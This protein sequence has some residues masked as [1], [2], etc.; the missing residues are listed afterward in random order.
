MILSPRSVKL[1]TR[2]GT[3][4]SRTLPHRYIRTIGA[5]CFVDH[6][7]PT[8]QS[9]AMSIAT[10]PHTGLQTVS[11]LFA[12][13]VEHRDSLGSVQIIKP[14]ELNLM[15]AGRG[16]AHSELST[17]NSTVAHGVQ[18]WTVLPDRD[19]KSAPLF[20]HYGELPEFQRGDLKIRLFIGELFGEESPA[21]IFSEL[22]GAEIYISPGA[23]AAIPLI[24]GNEYGTLVVE[25]DFSV[26]NEEVPLKSLHYSPA[27]KSSLQ[28]S[29]KNGARII[30]LGGEPFPEEI[31]MWWNFIGRSHEEIEEMRTR[32]NNEDPSIP[33]FQ[34]AVE[35]RIPAPEMPNLRLHPR[36]NVTP[37][38]I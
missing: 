6:F 29:T 19:R 36:G 15:T 22:L 37:P 2:S 3:E 8:N 21:R 18:L 13:E 1:T 26:D 5:W 11:W 7:G 16:V 17:E 25:G 4:I 10:H 30:F 12:G 27:G 24:T 32:W 33:T 38:L 31:V 35:G 23:T 20:D 9:D 14:G 34:A 28:L